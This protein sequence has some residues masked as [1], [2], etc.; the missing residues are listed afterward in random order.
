MKKLFIFIISLLCCLTFSAC[1]SGDAV[2]ET[3]SITVSVNNAEYG[4]V[5]KMSFTVDKNAEI[6]VNDNV[7]TI[8]ET[9]VVATAKGNDQQYI[10]VF[11]KFEYTGTNV[12]GDMVLTAV[13][14]RMER[15]YNV[16]FISNGQEFCE[17]EVVH[18]GDKLVKPISEP[19]KQ[20]DS[21]YEYVFAGWYNGENEWD[22]DNDTVKDDMVLTAKFNISA[23][24]TEEFLPSEL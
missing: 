10:Y 13:F 2:N 7:L 15:E 11:E 19:Q 3:Y 16:S 4:I 22:F 5:D 9:R 8:G 17:A 18:Y 23:T 12:N 6:V 14:S 21:L 1:D 24:Y 20:S